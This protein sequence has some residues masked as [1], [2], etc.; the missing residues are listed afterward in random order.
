MVSHQATRLAGSGSLLT[1][2]RVTWLSSNFLTRE[3]K[4]VTAELKVAR[5]GFPAFIGGMILLYCRVVELYIATTTS[6]VLF[7]AF[8]AYAVARIFYLLLK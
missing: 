1:A 7:T 6:A 4:K 2:R 5:G 8:A 3:D